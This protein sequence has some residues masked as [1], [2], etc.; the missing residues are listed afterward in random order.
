MVAA[1][2]SHGTENI[3]ELV[4]VIVRKSDHTTNARTKPFVDRHQLFH[5]LFVSCENHHCISFIFHVPNDGRYRLFTIVVI[6]FSCQRSSFVDKQHAS[7]GFFE[8]AG[9]FQRGFAH[10][11][12]HQMFTA[13]FQE[14]SI[15]HTQFSHTNSHGSGHRGL[16]STRIS[17]KSH[18]STRCIV[19]QCFTLSSHFFYDTVSIGL[20]IDFHFHDGLHI[21]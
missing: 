15:G 20:T 4:F 13:D 5:I 12:T 10:I 11:A 17:A 9:H 21:L 18:I 2:P 8:D 16:T 19:L 14:G 7:S 3:T 1:S 6:S